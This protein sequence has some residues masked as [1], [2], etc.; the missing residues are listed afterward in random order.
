MA[1]LIRKA[2]ADDYERAANSAERFAARHGINIDSVEEAREYVGSKRRAQIDVVNQL[3]TDIES[4]HSDQ[5]RAYL[6]KLWR[7][8]FRRAVDEPDATG[9]GWGSIIEED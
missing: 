7:A 5:G 8:C 6:R 3:N 2:F 1:Y 4:R 9:F